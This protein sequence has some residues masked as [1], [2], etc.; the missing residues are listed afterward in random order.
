[1]LLITKNQKDITKKKEKKEG[2]NSKEYES[3]KLVM[4]TS[5]YA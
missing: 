4:I 1:M 5:G 2:N 3:Q